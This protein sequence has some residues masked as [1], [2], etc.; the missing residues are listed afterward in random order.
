MVI[1]LLVSQ[2]IYTVYH[3]GLVVGNGYRLAQ[4][5]RQKTTLVTQKA[6]LQQTLAENHSLL[7]IQ[8][9]DMYKEF[10]PMTGV[11]NVKDIQAVASRWR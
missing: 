3:G 10:Q 1:G 6:Q 9:T 7:H 5:E 8:N 4:L 11:I 2:A